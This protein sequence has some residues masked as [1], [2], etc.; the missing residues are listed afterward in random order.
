MQLTLCFPGQGSVHAENDGTTHATMFEEG[1]RSLFAHYVAN[2]RSPVSVSVSGESVRLFGRR[3]Y[4]ILK[5]LEVGIVPLMK[6]GVHCMFGVGCEHTALV[7]GG[8][9]VLEGGQN[10]LHVSG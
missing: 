2:L 1:N 7:M 8:V 3:W 4:R 5:C 10:Q 6:V 9:D